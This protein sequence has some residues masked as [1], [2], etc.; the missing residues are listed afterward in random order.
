MVLVRYN[1]LVSLVYNIIVYI[2]DSN[3]H[4]TRKPKYVIIDAP[5][6]LGLRPTGVENLPDAL[7]EA[8][9]M[10]GLNAESVTRV[11]PNNTYDFRRDTDTLLLNGNSIRDFS[12]DLS[13]TVDRQIKRGFFPVVLGGDCSI[14]I[15]IMLGLRRMGR[16]GLFFI[17]G[18]SDF[19]QPSASI[20]GEVADM[21]LAFVTGRGPDIL[22]DIEGLK[23]LVKDE[24]VVVFGYRDAD[25]ASRYGSQ[26]V[27]DSNMH[28][29][30]LPKVMELQV[31]MATSTALNQLL[32]TT[33]KGFWVHLDADVLNDNIMPAVGYRMKG[34]LDF[35][36]LSK[37]LRIL[38]SSRHAVGM[39]I[40][41]F[42]PK[43]D[44]DGSIAENFVSS[45][46]SGLL[47]PQDT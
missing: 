15:G 27:K 43:L 6:N 9:L 17:D 12:I 13:N 4:L 34:G 21:D 42:N 14:L 45:I 10:K 44:V 1:I 19:Y 22:A 23:P 3:T 39:S 31:H 7:K 29:F 47:G 18:H 28:V 25:E 20:T 41:I 24:D 32:V 38:V 46:L 5:S 2:R 35:S 37:V 8:G 26:N 16:Y 36:E 30:D 33:K 40:T 11:Q